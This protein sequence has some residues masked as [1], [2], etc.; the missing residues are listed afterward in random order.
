VDSTGWESGHY[1]TWHGVVCNTNLKIVGLDLN[2]NNLDGTLPEE[3][4][5]IRSL[6]NLDLSNNHCELVNLN[7][8][9]FNETHSFAFVVVVVVVDWQWLELFRRP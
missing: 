7:Y 1:C 2:S 6:Q 4:G 9:K 5:L 3:L 8:W